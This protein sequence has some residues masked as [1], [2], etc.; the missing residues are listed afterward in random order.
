MISRANQP[1]NAGVTAE[2]ERLVA[3][4][5]R[6]Q[7]IAYIIGHR[8]FYSLDLKINQQVLIPRPETELL[9]DIALYMI[10]HANVQNILELG[11]GS[12]AIALA[13]AHH[14]PATDIVA[15][16]RD[17]NALQVAAENKRALGISNVR[18]IQSDWYSNLDHTKHKLD[19]IVA[20]PPYIAPDDTHLNQGDVRFEP[21][22]AL[23]SADRGLADLQH[24]ISNAPN[25]LSNPG[26]LIVEHG[27]DQ[28]SAVGELFSSAGFDQIAALKDLA[29][30]DRVSY[31]KI[32]SQG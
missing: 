23:I 3:A 20:N 24:I 25:F 18:F 29:G 2:V 31:G 15:V 26:G 11:T 32:I 12:G 28:A 16:D 8:E 14:A 6:G 1:L 17:A 30:N 9:V 10:E 4:R 5:Q 22:S 21:R 19:L 27:Y 13:I 7:P